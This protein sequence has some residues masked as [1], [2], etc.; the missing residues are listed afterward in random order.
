[1]RI[2]VILSYHLFIIIFKKYEG[3]L[4]HFNE[5]LFLRQSPEEQTKTL[6]KL[7]SL[8]LERAYFL[9]FVNLI[10]AI[11]TGIAFVYFCRHDFTPGL[12]WLYILSFQIVFI[13]LT[14]RF[15]FTE[16]HISITNLIRDIH[17]KHGLT[18]A[19]KNFIFERSE[20]LFS[21]RDYLAL[22]LFTLSF[23]V[24]MTMVFSAQGHLYPKAILAL[25]VGGIIWSRLFHQERRY[26]MEGILEIERAYESVGNKT[27]TYIP[28]ASSPHLIKIHGIF[29]KLMDKLTKY[30][31]EVM[32]WIAREG[33][34]SRFLAIGEISSLVGHDL[35][36]PIHG[37]YFSLTE[38]KEE[39]LDPKKRVEHLEYITKNTNRIHELANNL[40]ANLRNQNGGPKY[41]HLATSH[42]KATKLLHY[43][44]LK[45]EKVSLQLENF[46]DSKRVKVPSRDLVHILY[47]LYK[48]SLTNFKE[49]KIPSPKIILKFLH[50][51]QENKQACFQFI[52][53][54]TGLKKED[55]ENF[56]SMNYDNMSA[57]SFERGLGLRLI[58]NLI[59]KNGGTMNCTD[60]PLERGTSF[61]LEFPTA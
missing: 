49:N 10:K 48:N 52:D 35:K 44:S 8:P 31:K 32:N 13:P 38:L 15:I 25:V 50:W 55:F 40:N 4:P 58:R 36:G 30:E 39:G 7:Y 59:V 20:R 24:Q 53:N 22:P 28:L 45:L 54:G 17:H 57:H 61:I 42:D 2:P 46:E 51:N 18:A 16:S 1:M 41:N 37:I 5:M 14:S 34:E 21:L 11:P 12:A 6:K 43:E 29:N 47:N 60:C 23:M 33:E 9:I 3:L 56:T 27:K 19:F 26:L